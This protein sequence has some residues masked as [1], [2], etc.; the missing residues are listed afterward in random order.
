MDRLCGV[1]TERAESEVV[2]RVSGFIGGRTRL[3]HAAEP[4]IEAQADGVDEA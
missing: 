1:R 3:R 4:F 2:T